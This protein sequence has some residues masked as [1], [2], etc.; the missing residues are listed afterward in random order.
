MVMYDHHL[1]AREPDAMAQA[2]PLRCLLDELAVGRFT[3]FKKKFAP[4]D[5]VSLALI[6]D[7]ASSLNDKSINEI[8]PS[9][10]G[11]A[12]RG[13]RTTRHR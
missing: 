9:S 8:T 13:H 3:C 1:N 4:A 6:A 12:S 5:A 10:N 7:H 2:S 11:G